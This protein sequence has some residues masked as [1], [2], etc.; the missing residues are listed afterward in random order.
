MN[1]PRRW[2]GGVSLMSVI[3]VLTVGLLA[4]DRLDKAI[5]SRDAWRDRATKLEQ[6]TARL[7]ER[8]DDEAS[9]DASEDAWRRNTDKKVERVSDSVDLVMTRLGIK[10][11]PTLYFE[12]VPR[13]IAELRRGAAGLSLGP[14]PA[15]PPGTALLDFVAAVP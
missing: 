5:E 7:K 4:W 14:V 11:L 12:A 6:E 3:S 13:P 10:P 1:R 8:L 9:R 2:L 15:P